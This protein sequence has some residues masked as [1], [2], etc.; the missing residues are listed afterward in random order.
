MKLLSPI[1]I[2]CLYFSSAWASPGKKI[3]F[4]GFDFPPFFYKE[5][6]SFSGACVDV[7]KELCKA[8]NFQ[9]TFKI[10]PIRKALD[11]IKTGKIDLGGPF[12]FT[13]Q[14]QLKFYYS[15][16]LFK[17]SFGFFGLRKTVNQI[18]GYD[19]LKDLTVGVTFPSYTSISLDKIN[20]TVEGRMKIINEDLTMTPLTGVQKY[21]YS[22][23]YIN[24]DVGRYWIKSTG[25][26][27]IE[28]PNLS[29]ET[30]YHII[31]SRLEFTDEEF[32]KINQRLTKMIDDKTIH[33]IAAKYNLTAIK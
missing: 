23:A 19:D 33:K 7:V 11:M 24:R 3:T 4:V 13:A 5:G 20:E 15:P 8:E 18:K 21:K 32:E 28:V 25:S 12:A 16:P 22:L 29:D 6:S 27:L 17:T 26:S 2:F 14:R 31:F 1:F 9:C 10:Q 30:N